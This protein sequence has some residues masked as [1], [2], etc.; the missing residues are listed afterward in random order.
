MIKFKNK[1]IYGWAKS[2]FSK[3]DYIE[4]S[5]IEII[6]EIFDYAKKNNKKISFR[7]GGR[8]YGDN[9]LNK[10]NIVL[11]YVSKENILSFDKK[12]G[13]IEVSGSCSLLNLFK[14]II[15]KGWTLN[16]SPASQFITIAG[17]I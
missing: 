15:S 2:D 11:K 6:K 1:K 4:T 10:N 17:A 12:N 14:F 9:T 16:V 5:N 7:S 3:C 13:E 8:S